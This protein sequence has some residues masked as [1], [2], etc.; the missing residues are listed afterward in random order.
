[1]RQESCHEA[2]DGKQAKDGILLFLRSLDP[3]FRLG[4]SLADFL[5]PSE[6]RSNSIELW[7]GHGKSHG[8]YV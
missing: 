4:G 7:I 3:G 6:R 8:S 2:L 1:M 5:I